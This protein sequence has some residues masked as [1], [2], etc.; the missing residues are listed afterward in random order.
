MIVGLYHLG[1][2]IFL[3]K[4]LNKIFSSI[5]ELKYQKILVSVNLILFVFYPIILFTNYGSI[6]LKIVAYII[7]ILGIFKISKAFSGLNIPRTVV[8]H[9]PIPCA[10]PASIMLQIAG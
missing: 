5:S 6:I 7:F 4:S 1:T 8:K 10:L 9:V 3:N 2:L